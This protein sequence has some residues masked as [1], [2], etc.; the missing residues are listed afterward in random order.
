MASAGVWTQRQGIEKESMAAT[1]M[2]AKP[3]LSSLRIQDS[4]RSGSKT[5]KFL[6]YA[7]AALG[8][9]VLIAGASFALRNQTPVVEVVTAEKPQAGGLE[10]I[11]NASGYVT[12]RRR[13]TI[14]AK[15]TGR[16]TGVF[17]DEGTHVHPGQLL[18]TLDDSD[19]RR[20]LDSA[21]ADRNASQAAIADLQVQL[22]LAQIQLRRAQELRKAG[23]QS[24]EQLD[25]SSSAAD[26]LAAK[27]ELAKEQVQ[28][29]DARI[30]EAQ[31]AVDNCV[32]NAPYDGI[33]VSKDAQ[34]GEMVS[35]NSAGGGFTRTGIAT[36]VDMNSNE[37]EVDV[38]ES[39]IARVKDRQPV[40]AI[41]DA[42]PNWEI[43]SHV[44][45]VIPT[46]DRQKA[47]VKV[48]ISFDKLD[49]RILPDM[50]VKV[51]F[52]ED[53]PVKK[54][55]AS[56]PVVAAVLPNEALHDENGK[57][58]VFLVK[59]D[60]LERRAVAVG[61]T[62][63]TQTEILSGLVAGDAVVLRGPANLQDGQA[64]QIKK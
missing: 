64:V 15:I 23:V 19:A 61:N 8:V 20:A 14:A 50:G 12:P 40:T 7:S 58:I 52:L 4:H 26:S 57:K 33:V 46:A 10:A 13:A 45:T 28:A 31:Q 2:Q 56:A 32:I 29:A 22:H 21:K 6:R 17:F 27:I 51:T 55:D 43:P 30:R 11:L 25:T 48:R 63:G 47:T 39:Y 62:Q 60:R 18:A 35:P 5:G 44:R 1:E 9:V 42:Y 34:V 49:P 3:D 41:L 59:N 16:V 37:I 36:I 24:Q 54:K 38:N 53:A